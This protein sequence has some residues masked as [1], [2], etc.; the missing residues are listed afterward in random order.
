MSTIW[1][2]IY[3]YNK[4]YLDLDLEHV[5]QELRAQTPVISAEGM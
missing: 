3:V 1:Q 4:R 2:L 5:L